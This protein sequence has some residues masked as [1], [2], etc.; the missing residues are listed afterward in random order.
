MTKKKALP[1]Y[2]G[3]IED[4]PVFELKKE[5]KTKIK[6]KLTKSIQSSISSITK[7]SSTALSNI[8]NAQY[9][10]VKVHNTTI[11]CIP[12]EELYIHCMKSVRDN[13]GITN[14]KEAHD[15]IMCNS[16]WTIFGFN[17]EIHSKK[18]WEYDKNA[19]VFIIDQFANYTFISKDF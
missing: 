12:D 4:L 15:F 18:R 11:E 6:R 5:P 8:K 13:H 17:P 3:N 1:I 2:S 14:V 10:K 16:Y 19:K 7:S 9:F